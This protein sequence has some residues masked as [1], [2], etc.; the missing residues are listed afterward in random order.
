MNALITGASKGMGKAIAQQLAAQSYNLVL[1]ARNVTDL[2]N[3]AAELQILYPNLSIYT[4]SADCE[5]IEQVKKIAK[6]TQE[7]VGN[8][9]VLINNVGLFIPV[10]LLDDHTDSLTRLINVNVYAA[11]Y[12]STFFGKKMRDHKSG[13][14]FNICS[15]ASLKPMP[16]SGPY[17]VSKFALLGLTKVLREELMAHN[18]KVTAILPGAT[19]TDSWAGTDLPDDRFVAPEDVAS[20]IVNCL[21]M[22][23]GANVDEIIIR[24]LKGDI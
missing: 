5:D 2:N 1:C 4:F 16:N 13:H 21:N 11:H 15:V 8:L 19:R 24:P 9:D 14:I 23:K 17:T 20:I 10:S 3:L 12:L 22:S 18:V 6:F 7:Q